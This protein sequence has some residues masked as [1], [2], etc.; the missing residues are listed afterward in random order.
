MSASAPKETIPGFEKGLES[1][2]FQSTKTTKTSYSISDDKKD[3]LNGKRHEVGLE[4]GASED[5]W[6]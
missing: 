1:L 4:D 2:V 6:G 3:I 5:P